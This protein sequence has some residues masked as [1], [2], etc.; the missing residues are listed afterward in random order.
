M[1]ARAIWKAHICFGSVDVPVKLYSAVQ[2]RTVHFR[3]LDAKRHEPVKQHMVDPD[4]GKVVDSA[5]IR[6]AYETDEGEL[7]ILEAGD[8][9]QVTPTPSRDIRITQFVPPA[10]ITHQWYDRPYFL[11]PDE[12]DGAYFALAAALR[13]RGVEGVARWVMRNKEYVGA[14]RAEGDYLMLITLRHA[15]EVVPASALPR[16]TGRELD[17]REISMAK[18]LVKAMEDPFDITAYHD[19]YRERV[20]ELVQA[21]AAGK[22]VKFPKAPKKQGETSLADVLEASLAASGGKERKRA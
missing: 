20:L 2:D 7:V 9:E 15:G 4:T 11:G 16:P 18:Q 1:G 8:L 21:K 3:L 17:E 10:E 14:L 6:R 5:D 22:V 19:E 13:K 12:E